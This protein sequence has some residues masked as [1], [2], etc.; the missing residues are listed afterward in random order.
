M[1]GPPR[2]IVLDGEKGFPMG[3]SIDF[4]EGDGTELKVTSPAP[5]GEAG[6]TEQAGGTWQETIC[7][8]RRKFITNSW[9]DFYE[10]VDS[11][12]ILIG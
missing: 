2:N 6:K 4:V 5:P 10:F 1:Y 12:N 9:D 7:M 3:E 8:A 11:V